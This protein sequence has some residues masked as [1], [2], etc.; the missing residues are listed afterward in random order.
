MYFFKKIK[1]ECFVHI[2]CKRCIY[3][4]HVF[5]SK[6]K[7]ITHIVRVNLFSPNFYFQINNNIVYLEIKTQLIIKNKC[8]AFNY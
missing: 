6:P 8:F 3:L 2:F 1:S 7:R 4:T 5:V